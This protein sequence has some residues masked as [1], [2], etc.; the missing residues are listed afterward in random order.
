MLALAFC[1]LSQTDASSPELSN[2]HQVNTQLYR[3]AQPRAGGLRILKSLGVRT[4]LNLRG[5]AAETRA[6]GDQARQLGLRYYSVP[7]PDLS[8]PSD[9]DVQQAL[10]IINQTENQ[11]VFVHCHHGEDRT[12]TIIACYRIS[13][14]GWTATDARKEA[15]KF[16]MSWLQ[17]GMKLCIDKFYQ[18]WQKRGKTDSQV[19]S[20]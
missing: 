17:R 19:R 2:F 20:N 16:G 4:I 10:A 3:G 6:E 8:A 15:E 13:H 14:D 12:G 7:L 18:E 5:G 1:L 9:K 11:P